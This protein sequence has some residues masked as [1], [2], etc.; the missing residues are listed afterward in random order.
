MVKDCQKLIPHE[1]CFDVNGVTIGCGY[2][3]THQSSQS[4]LISARTTLRLL[5]SGREKDLALYVWAVV[6][7]LQQ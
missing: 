6:V 4:N 2:F 7:S 1:H 5:G 3:A